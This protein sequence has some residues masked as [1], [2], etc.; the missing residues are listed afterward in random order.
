MKRP[1][2]LL[3][4]ATLLLVGCTVDISHKK[5]FNGA[6]GAQLVTKRETF[7]FHWRENEAVPEFRKTAILEDIASELPPSPGKVVMGPGRAEV[8]VPRGQPV[9]VHRIEKEIGDGFVYYYAL[10]EVYVPT[11]HRFVPFRYA[12]GY[13]DKIFRAPW[14]GSEVPAVRRPSSLM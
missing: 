12:W 2:P 1:L 5:I 11:L 9:R 10:G 13:M 14:E 7:L 6:V 3:V 4:S 8:H